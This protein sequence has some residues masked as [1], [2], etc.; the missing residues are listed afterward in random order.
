MWASS[1]SRRSFCSSAS[2]YLFKSIWQSQQSL[3]KQITKS[4]TKATGKS[5]LF[6]F[7][8]L[9]SRNSRKY[10]LQPFM[11]TKRRFSSLQLHNCHHLFTDFKK[12]QKRLW[13]SVDIRY[14]TTCYFNVR[15][16]ADISQL[17]LPHGTDIS[18]KNLQSMQITADS[19]HHNKNRQN[20]WFEK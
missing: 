3:S 1:R 2:R 4:T 17:N 13:I 12:F 11:A 8:R 9:R 20:N 16:K 14:D 10:S 19:F 18:S 5:S 15:S 6:C 7:S